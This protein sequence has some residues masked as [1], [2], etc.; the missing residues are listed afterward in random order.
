[1]KFDLK[2]SLEEMEKLEQKYNIALHVDQY[3]DKKD[4]YYIVTSNGNE[5]IGSTIKEV[6]KRL[7]KKYDY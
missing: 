1:M 3:I 7:K 5:Y 4:E 2:I 6:K